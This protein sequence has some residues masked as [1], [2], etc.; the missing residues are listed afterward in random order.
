MTGLCLR[1]DFLFPPHQNH[2]FGGSASIFAIFVD[3]L[4]MS[5]TSNFTPKADLETD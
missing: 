4:S 2:V 5:K 1:S 3:C